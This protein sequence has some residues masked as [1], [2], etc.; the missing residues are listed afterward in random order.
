M[1]SQSDIAII[2]PAFNE[3]SS[4]RSVVEPIFTFT[5]NVI[6]IDD[7]STDQTVNQL[8]G[9]PITVL[10]NPVNRGKGASL[11]QGFQYAQRLN[12]RA[13]ICMDADTQHDPHDIP[14]FIQAMNEFP[15]H[16][17][18][19][20]RIHNTENAPKSRY[21]ANRVADFFISWAAGRRILDTQSGYRL[22]PI[23][24]L[25]ECLKQPRFRHFTFESDLIITGSRHGYPP[26]S[27]P[28]Q[29][30]YPPNSRPSYYRPIL[31]TV[32]IAGMVTWKILSRGLCVPGLIRTLFNLRTSTPVK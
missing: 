5:D 21:R 7:G 19:G 31:D 28:I 22:Y 1:N 20:A 10:K 9:L 3:A 15:S 13:A 32:K 4:I 14:K 12:I 17:I 25:R 11:W 30:H 29:S 23:D 24:F 18:I 16:I 8:T 6:V 27:I 26:V 2:I